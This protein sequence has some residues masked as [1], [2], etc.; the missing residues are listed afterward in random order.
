MIP[1]SNPYQLSLNS[2]SVPKV[3]ELEMG[4]VNGVGTARGLAGIFSLYNQ[5]RLVKQGGP[6]W[7]RVLRRRG[8]L[9]RDLIIALPVDWNCGYWLSE[10]PHVSINCAGCVKTPSRI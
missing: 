10:T 2:V 9:T 3:L 1:V 8:K 7:R 4:A 5:G 6:A